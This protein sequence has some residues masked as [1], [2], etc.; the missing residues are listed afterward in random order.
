[1]KKWILRLIMGVAILAMGTI[2]GICLAQR[3]HTAPEIRIPSDEVI[4]NEEVPEEELL[5][6][7]EAYDDADGDVTDTLRISSIVPLEAEG[8]AKVVYVAHDRSMNMVTAIRKVNY[9]NLMVQS[10]APDAESPLL[11]LNSSVAILQKG[12][13][14][15]PFLYIMTANDDKD[16]TEELKHR[17][18]VDG[19]YDLTKSG[20]YKLSFTVADADGNNSNAVE[21]LLVVE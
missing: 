21:F 19:N 11:Q 17:L 7:V 5:H 10:V 3:D 4:Y 13:I 20:R 15:D 9:Q 14:F 16:T 2:T 12:E 1:M 6:G 18:S 8:A